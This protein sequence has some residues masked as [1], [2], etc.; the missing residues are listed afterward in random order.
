MFWYDTIRL[1][2]KETILENCFVLQVWKTTITCLN[3]RK[4]LENV[5]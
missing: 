1:I 2:L 4:N 3:A 5:W